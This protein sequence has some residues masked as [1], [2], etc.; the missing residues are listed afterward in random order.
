MVVI[1]ELN[2]VESCCV[3]VYCRLAGYFTVIS[4]ALEF[5]ECHIRPEYVVIIRVKN[6][7]R[8]SLRKGNQYKFRLRTKYIIVKCRV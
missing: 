2:L 3:R 7:N 1:R 4:L 6:F 8:F 5:I